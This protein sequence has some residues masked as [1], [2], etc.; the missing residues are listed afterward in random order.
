[1]YL[2]K[3]NFFVITCLPLENKLHKEGNLFLQY[4]LSSTQLGSN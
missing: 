1:M 3:N 2:L 4:R